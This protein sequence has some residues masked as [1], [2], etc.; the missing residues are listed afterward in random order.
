MMSSLRDLV[1]VVGRD[2]VV[3]LRYTAG[4]TSLRR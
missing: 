3:A 4:Y 2:P 1:V